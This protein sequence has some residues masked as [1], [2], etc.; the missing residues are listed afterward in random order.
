MRRAQFHGTS[1]VPRNVSWDVTL[2]RVLFYGTQRMGCK[3]YDEFPLGS[4][5]GPPVV[6]WAVPMARVIFHG[7]QPMCCLT[8]YEF[9]RG[10]SHGTGSALWDVPLVVLMGHVLSHEPF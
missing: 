6:P 5:H 3:T 1:S 7:T 10:A 4:Y 2:E 8:L 9:R